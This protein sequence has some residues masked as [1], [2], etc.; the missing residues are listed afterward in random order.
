[1][2]DMVRNLM[3]SPVFTQQISR[4][5]IGMNPTEDN[6]PGSNRFPHTVEREEHM[7]LVQLG[8]RDGSTGYDRF[9]VAK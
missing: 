5:I 1:M 4:I 2:V 8:M 9:V 7:S 6:D 3:M